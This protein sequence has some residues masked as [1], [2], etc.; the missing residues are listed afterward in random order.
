MTAQ[1]QII[2]NSIRNFILFPFLWVGHLFYTLGIGH[3]LFGLAGGIT[4]FPNGQWTRLG[5]I[6][7][8]FE[9]PLFVPGSYFLTKSNIGPCMWDGSIWSFLFHGAASILI[10]IATGQLIQ[11]VVN[12]DKIK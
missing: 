5:G 3:W 7:W 11:K 10:I 12:K 4:S 6:N 2:S 1:R 9:I 8:A